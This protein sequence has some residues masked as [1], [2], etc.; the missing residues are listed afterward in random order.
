[1]VA[2]DAWIVIRPFVV[3]LPAEAFKVCLQ[4]KRQ[5]FALL[6]S[7]DLIRQ[8]QPVSSIK[9]HCTIMLMSASSACNETL[10]LTAP[11]REFPKT[12]PVQHIACGA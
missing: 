5:M 10:A 4:A 6:R 1:M 8:S 7:C 12:K 11:A 2:D 9:Q 3:I